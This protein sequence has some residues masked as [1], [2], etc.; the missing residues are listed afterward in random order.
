MRHIWPL[1]SAKTWCLCGLDALI[2]VSVFCAERRLEVCWGIIAG[3]SAALWDTRPL[4]LYFNR[5]KVLRGVGTIGVF[6]F[7]SVYDGDR[8]NSASL[9][10]SAS[11]LR[12][13]SW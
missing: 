10:M 5:T 4:E 11:L 8:I 6:G 13:A 7:Q 2:N 3:L 12:S 9:L 1:T